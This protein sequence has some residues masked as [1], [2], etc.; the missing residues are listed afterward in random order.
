MEP[1]GLAY[2]DVLLNCEVDNATSQLSRSPRGSQSNR[3]ELKTL[4]ELLVAAVLAVIGSDR[5]LADVSGGAIGL[6][7]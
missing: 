7:S 6:F 3:S 4:N 5:E 2:A 1:P